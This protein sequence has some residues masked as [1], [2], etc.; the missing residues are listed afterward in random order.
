MIE[1]S[2]KNKVR[3]HF[4]VLDEGVEEHNKSFRI[5]LFIEDEMKEEAMGKSKKEAEQSAAKKLFLSGFFDTW[6]NSL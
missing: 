2:Q 1:W 3:V 5:G 4:K 6:Q